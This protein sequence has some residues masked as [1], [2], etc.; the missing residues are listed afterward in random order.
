MLLRLRVAGRCALLLTLLRPV[1]NVGKCGGKAQVRQGADECWLL[2]S[3][4]YKT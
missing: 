2:D 4:S 3:P 1:V